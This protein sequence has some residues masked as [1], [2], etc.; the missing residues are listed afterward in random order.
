MVACGPVREERLAGL[1]S[2]GGAAD[3][4][5]DTGEVCGGARCGS[6]RGWA[7]LAAD[8]AAQSD[9]VTSCD[10]RC[11][12][13]LLCRAV[14]NAYLVCVVAVAHGAFVAKPVVGSASPRGTIVTSNPDF[15]LSEL[16]R[17]GLSFNVAIKLAPLQLH[18]DGGAV[19]DWAFVGSLHV[20]VIAGAVD[21]VTA[22]HG[23]DGGGG[24]EH[25]FAA[26]RT[27]ALCGAL[28]AAVLCDPGD[29]DADVASL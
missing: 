21:V 18:I 26:Y 14:D 24:S 15:C 17:H 25:P 4:V 3:G 16:V 27:V 12:G 20:S 11:H 2:A 23:N 1:W 9:A 6:G 5:V 29:G 10:L 28:D 13:L 7:R 22:F 19:A 8:G